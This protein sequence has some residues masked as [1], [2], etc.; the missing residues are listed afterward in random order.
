MIDRLLFTRRPALGVDQVAILLLAPLAI[1][2][3]A[4]AGPAA[5]WGYVLGLCSQPFFIYAAFRARQ[6][7]TLIVSVLYVGI[8]IRGIVN[9]FAG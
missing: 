7:A 1:W 4:E 3:L 5:R 2:L 8:W 6:P 9:H